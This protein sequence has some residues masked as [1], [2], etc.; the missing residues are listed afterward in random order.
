M[1]RLMLALA[2]VMTASSLSGCIIDP[3]RGDHRYYDN[4]CDH[5]GDRDCHDDNWRH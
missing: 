2:I 3:H 5:H 4:R 1:K